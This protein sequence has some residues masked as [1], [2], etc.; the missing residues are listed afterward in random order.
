MVRVRVRVRVWVWVK[1]GVALVL[2]PADPQHELAKVLSGGEP[3]RRCAG[4]CVSLVHLD[5]GA[6]HHEGAVTAA[7]HLLEHMR[8]H[9]APCGI[10]AAQLVDTRLSERPSVGHEAVECGGGG[11]VLGGDDVAHG[12]G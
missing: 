3:R 1:V 6:L 4:G 12:L 7:S 5:E 2:L 11:G 10:G 9:G 8:G